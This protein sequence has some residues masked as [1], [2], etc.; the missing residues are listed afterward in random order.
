MGVEEYLLPSSLAGVLAQR[1]VRT[2]CDGCA[3]PRKISAAFR[4]EI[5]RDAG[6]VPE[7]T[8][9]VGAGCEACGGTGYRGRTAIFELLPVTGGIKELILARA[10]AVAI[11]NRAVEEGMTLL[12]EDGWTKVRRGETTI[13]EVLRVTRAG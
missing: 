1:L 10:D 3:A 12:R 13:E 6:F 2:V 5:A 9:R 7:G 11:R 4:D 8:L